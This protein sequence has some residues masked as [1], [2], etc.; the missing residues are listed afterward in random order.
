[1]A[2][3]AFIV[4]REPPRRDPRLTLKLLDVIARATEGGQ[5]VRSSEL[6]TLRGWNSDQVRRELKLLWD[7]GLIRGTDTKDLSNSVSMLIRDLTPAGWASLEELHQ[8]HR[9]RARWAS[10]QSWPVV[11]RWFFGLGVPAG[12]AL[13]GWLYF[14]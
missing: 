1:M 5:S 11:E 4:G 3:D 14:G 9:R 13:L 6:E 7:G 12:L 10:R 8:R 2:T